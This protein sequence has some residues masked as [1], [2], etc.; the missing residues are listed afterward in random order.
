MRVRVKMY[1]QDLLENHQELFV[2]T[3]GILKDDQLSYFENDKKTKHVITF[4]DDRVVI[5]RYGDVSTFT[6]LCTNVK[7]ECLIRSEDGDMVLQAETE[8]ITRTKDK[9]IVAYRVLSDRDVVLHQRIRWE[10]SERIKK[11]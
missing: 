11:D 6:T 9:W 5:E 10:L 8:N 4:K 1:R 3:V 2:D 7:S